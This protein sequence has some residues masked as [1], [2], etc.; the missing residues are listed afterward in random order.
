MTKRF[1]SR[2]LAFLLALALGLVTGC[3][4]DD[5]FD[6]HPPAGQG[7]MI[8]NNDTFHDVS[9]F[10]DS[11]RVEEVRD[12]R[13][14]AYNLDPGVYRVVLE[15]QGGGRSFRGDIDILEGRNTVLDVLPG[16][17]STRYAVEVFF[18]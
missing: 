6:H 8:V 3:E 2:C 15:E 12:D 18:D 13:K 5:D 11:R 17:S 16:G 9:V 4:D 1:D 14:R 7:A 10:I